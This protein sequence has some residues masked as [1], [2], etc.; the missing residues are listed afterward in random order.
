MINVIDKPLNIPTFKWSEFFWEERYF[1]VFEENVKR[2]I[3]LKFSMYLK[4]I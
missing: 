4:Y 1:F 3:I 2:F